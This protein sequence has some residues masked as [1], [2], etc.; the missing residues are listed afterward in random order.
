M[1]GGNPEY[2]GKPAKAKVQTGNQMDTQRWERESNPG[3]V[4]G[5][6]RMGME[7]NTAT[8]PA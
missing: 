1:Q 6:Q 2:L 5:P 4:C 7:T 8:L 3:S